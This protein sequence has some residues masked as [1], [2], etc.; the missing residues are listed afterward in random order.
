MAG[1]YQS[2]NQTSRKQPTNLTKNQQE[3][4]H[5]ENAEINNTSLYLKQ[6]TTPKSNY[7]VNK[8]KT[9]LNFRIMIAT[10]VTSLQQTNQ[11]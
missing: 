8:N 1:R 6:Y 4:G 2:D 7:T 11:I 10:L 9:E 3:K 5:G